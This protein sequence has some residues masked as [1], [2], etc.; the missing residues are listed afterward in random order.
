M[1]ANLDTTAFR[2]TT[3]RRF[4]AGSLLTLAAAGCSGVHHPAC[5]PVPAP[6]AAPQG[7]RPYP[8]R[9]T[10]AAS[11]LKDAEARGWGRGWPVDRSA[12][13]RHVVVPGS[14]RTIAVHHALAPIVGRCL[15]DTVALGY[16]LADVA[17][18]GGYVNRPMLTPSGNATSTPSNHSWG[19]AVDLN[20][21]R[22]PMS[23][24]LVTDIPE[25]VAVLWEEWGFNWGGRWVA[26]GGRLADAMHFEYALTI[27]DAHHDAARAS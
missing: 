19:T 11:S 22:N 9:R 24:R 13:M 3:R 21:Q 10:T 5:M 12:E 17:D 4:L 1:L 7:G 15:H 18:E 6:P 23:N 2:P 16:R 14:D 25:A 26:N 20:W 8:G 27:H